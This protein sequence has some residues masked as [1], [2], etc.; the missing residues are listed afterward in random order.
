MARASRILSTPWPTFSASKPPRSGPR[1]EAEYFITCTGVVNKECPAPRSRVNPRALPSHS[2]GNRKAHKECRRDNFRSLRKHQFDKRGHSKAVTTTFMV[3]SSIRRKLVNACINGRPEMNTENLMERI[4]TRN[5]RSWT[6]KPFSWPSLKLES[7]F[8]SNKPSAKADTHVIKMHHKWPNDSGTK[9]FCSLPVNWRPRKRLRAGEEFS[10]IFRVCFSVEKRLGIK[11][12]NSFIANIIIIIKDSN[13]SVDTDASLPYNHETLTREIR[14]E[15]ENVSAVEI[16]KQPCLTPSSTMHGGSLL[17]HHPER[18]EKTTLFSVTM[19]RRVQIGQTTA[20]FAMDG[21]PD[22]SPRYIRSVSNCLFANLPA[23][24]YTN[25][26]SEVTVVKDLK[27]SQFQFHG[28]RSLMH[29]FPEIRGCVALPPCPSQI[30]KGLGENQVL[31]TP[32]TGILR[33]GESEAITCVVQP[34]AEGTFKLQDTQSRT[35]LISINETERAIKPPEREVAYTKYGSTTVTCTWTA[36][37][38][39]QSLK[40]TLTVR[41]LPKDLAGTLDGKTTGDLTLM[42]GDKTALQCGFLPPD[43]AGML[44]G[45]WNAT[46]DPPEAAT[47]QIPEDH[48]KAEI[49]PPTEQGFLEVPG[50]FSV[51]CVFYSPE[52]TVIHEFTQKV[53]VTPKTETTNAVPKKRLTEGNTTALF[54]TSECESFPCFS[55]VFTQQQQQILAVISVLSCVIMPIKRVRDLKR[56]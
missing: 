42:A 50:E 20:T 47:I 24:T 7:S 28:W 1:E 34:S 46:A 19:I 54:R 10:A 12:H 26:G 38:G 25:C 22:L 11:E 35:D 9:A 51:R 4:S 39:G 56:L 45:L 53:I 16:D 33:V 43:A 23:P 40:K 29:K 8:G 27:A 30:N 5:G 6:L 15:T 14:V 55:I 13:I 37:S 31:F 48:T 21:F 49:L 3:K 17:G 52:N 41:I 2:K 32:G 18:H 44:N 36:Q